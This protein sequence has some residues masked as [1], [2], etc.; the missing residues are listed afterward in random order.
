MELDLILKVGLRQTQGPDPVQRTRYRR[1][2]VLAIAAG[3]VLV[4]GAGLLL[5]LPV[6]PGALL[7]YRSA[8]QVPSPLLAG[9]RVSVTLIR[10]REGSDVHRVIAPREAGVL[11]VRVAPDSSP[12]R[13]GYAM[14][15]ALESVIPHAV[16]LDN[17]LPDANGYIQV[18]LPLAAVAGK[19]L[20]ISV[21]PSPATGSES[22]SFRVQ[23]QYAPN[24]P[25]DIR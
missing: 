14:G 22:I 7:A 21:N 25:V 20:R 17:L 15:I 3:L 8:T 24:T 11:A 10:L 9:P 1:R 23:V 2:M 12:G 6:R 16:T 18:Y 4:V 13:Q 19:D 5:L